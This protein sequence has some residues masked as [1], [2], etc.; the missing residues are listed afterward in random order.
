MSLRKTMQPFAV[1][2]GAALTLA[3]LSGFAE[4]LTVKVGF[5]A[6]LTGVNAGYGKDL[7]NGVRLAIDEANAQ[8]IK[9]GDKVA[10]FDLVSEDDQADPRI[11]VQ[12]AQKLVDGGVS[13]VVGHFNSGTTIPASQIYEQA[14][15]PVIDPAATNPTITGRGFANTFMVISTDAQNAGNAGVYAVEVTKAK[16]IAIIDDRTAF[17]QGE[18]DE[19][20]KAVKAHGGTIVT[21]EYTDNKSVDFST[22][23]TKIKST[24]ADLIFFGGLDTQAAGIAKRMKQ[25][26]ITAQLVGGGGVEDPEFIKLAGDAAEGVMAWEYGRPLSQLPGGKDFSQ[27]FK[28]RF[29]VDILSYAPFGYDAA[30][31]AIKAMEAAKSSTPNVYRPALKSINFEGITG[32]IAFDST[33]ALKNASSTLYQVKDGVWVPIVTKKGV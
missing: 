33:G 16:R 6:P 31:A 27:K 2:V 24:N 10:H 19:F 4:D 17:G 14:G 29:G 11:G 26:G 9:I 30:W 12:A 32:T 5:A 8:K 22:Q 25:L 1:L 18:A 13:V 3:P 23:L 15:I 20:E 21:R 28:Q 7:Q